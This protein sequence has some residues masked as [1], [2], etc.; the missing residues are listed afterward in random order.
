MEHQSKIV[1]S[2]CKYMIQPAK[3]EK[4]VIQCSI[5]PNHSNTKKYRLTEKYIS[6]VI[7]S[8]K[9]PKMKRSP[10]LVSR[11]ILPWQIYHG[12]R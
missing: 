2:P 10:F 6:T 3:S 8:P 5:Q 11:Y 4:D 7:D 9:D 1:L 12:H